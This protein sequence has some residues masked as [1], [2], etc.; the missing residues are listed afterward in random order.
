MSDTDPKS[1]NQPFVKIGQA[2]KMLGV[3]AETLRRWEK[4]GKLT[5]VRTVGGTRVYPVTHL[6]QLNPSA[7]K[8]DTRRKPFYALPQQEAA[9]PPPQPPVIQPQLNPDNFVIPQSGTPEAQVVINSNQAPYSWS[10][11][12]SHFNQ[13]NIAIFLVV[14]LILSTLTSFIIFTRQTNTTPPPSSRTVAGNNT[15][16]TTSSSTNTSSSPQKTLSTSSPNLPI[17]AS[18]T[19]QG[20]LS[21]ND[22]NTFNNKQ[23]AL[24]FGNLTTTTDGLTIAGGTNAVVGPGTIINL[25]TADSSHSGLLSKNDWSVFNNKQNTL[26]LG[27]ITSNTAALTITGGTDAVVGMGVTVNLQTATSTQSG[28]LSKD[29]WNS[30]NGREPTIAPGTV[31][32]YFRGDKTWQ[33]LD[34]TAVGLGN[35]E[36]TALS[37]WAG[38]KNITTLGT[39]T[40]GTW[41]GTIIDV[42]HGG[43]GITASLTGVLKANGTSQF[44]TML[45]NANTLVKWTDSS[46]LGNSLISESG[47]TVSI[48]GDLSLNGG[49]GKLTVGTID[50]PY[51]IDGQKYATYTTSMT[52]VKEETTGNIAVRQPTNGSYSNVINF[53]TAATGSDLWLFSRVTNLKNNINQMVV[54]LTP[55]DNTRVWYKIDPA[56]QTLTVYSS[57]PT[58]VSYRLT[59]PRFDT[60]NWPNTRQDSNPGLMVE[61]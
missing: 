14:F 19:Q 26:N 24:T 3:T 15:S 39:I 46:T 9:T 30:F 38:S 53:S 54:L 60:A 36:N 35:V 42:L 18:S 49:N 6:Q 28:L 13:V 59:A 50:P 37:T 22:W 8:I 31:L 32:Q 52:G 40:T 23:N 1:P 55:T 25:Y 57:Q 29:D 48:A 58:S 45:G 16:T 5:P 61:Y 51:T 7:P 20:I 21:S 41:N 56:G 11:V 10:N 12:K 44:T 17:F 27:D 4:S 43:T 34:S 47:T 2:S 33:T